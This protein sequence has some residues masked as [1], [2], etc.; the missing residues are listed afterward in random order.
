VIA[1]SPQSDKINSANLCSHLLKLLY[2]HPFVCIT[3][4]SKLRQRIKKIIDD[5]NHILEVKEIV[6]RVLDE[7]VGKTILKRS[8]SANY[9]PDKFSIEETDECLTYQDSL[10]FF[11]N[12]KTPRS[13]Q[14]EVQKQPSPKEEIKYDSLT[15]KRNFIIRDKSKELTTED[16]IGKY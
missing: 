11:L 1:Q 7:V 15:A 9:T 6:S 8:Q 13:S 2:S 14:E 4:K 12:L 16:M 3:N 5:N 10:P